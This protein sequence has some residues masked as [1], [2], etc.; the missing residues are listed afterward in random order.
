MVTKKTYIIPFILVLCLFACQSKQ[1]AK[2][3]ASSITEAEKKEPP[4]SWAILPPLPENISDLYE[5]CEEQPPTPIDTTKKG[6]KK[7]TVKKKKSDLFR[8]HATIF[9]E[10]LKNQDIATASK[11]SADFGLKSFLNMDMEHLSSFE[12]GACENDGYVG[13]A[14]VT[15]NKSIRHVFYFNRKGGKGNWR[16][17]GVKNWRD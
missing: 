4:T 3:A 13:T 15:L 17:I 6:N 2:V 7:K 8:K 10:S 16:F 5:I 11:Y 1:D 9:L 12:I 14:R